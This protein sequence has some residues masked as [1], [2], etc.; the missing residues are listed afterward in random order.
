MDFVTDDQFTHFRTPL[1]NRMK[2]FISFS[3]PRYR[4]AE[5]VGEKTNFL[6]CILMRYA[7]LQYL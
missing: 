4:W 6:S 2:K 5:G 3:C 1:Q 7:K